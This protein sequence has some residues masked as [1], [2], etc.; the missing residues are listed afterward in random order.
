MPNLLN[1]GVHPPKDTSAELWYSQ[2]REK[3]KNRT[4]NKVY[5]RQRSPCLHSI[6]YDNSPELEENN[7]TREEIQHEYHTTTQTLTQTPQ[8][9]MIVEEDPSM[10]ANMQNTLALFQIPRI[11]TQ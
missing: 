10:P 9:P 1:K 11:I 3:G 5:P 2:T 8:E 7:Q 6:Q 4:T